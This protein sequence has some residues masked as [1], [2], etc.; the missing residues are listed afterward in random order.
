MIIFKTIFFSIGLFGLSIIWLL[1]G[2]IYVA[3]N[4][5]KFDNNCFIIKFI[6]KMFAYGPLYVIIVVLKCYYRKGVKI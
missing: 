3:M 4:Q 5:E 6:K 1:F 2:F